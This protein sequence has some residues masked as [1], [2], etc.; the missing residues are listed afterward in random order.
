MGA[1]TTIVLK[2]FVAND[3]MLDLLIRRSDM[4]RD[5]PDFLS[6]QQVAE[7]LGICTATVRTMLNEHG[8]FG[9]KASQRWV[10]PKLALCAWLLGSDMQTGS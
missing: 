1:D 9:R 6:V 5:Y 10:I 7:I 3:E 2:P 8:L 4:L